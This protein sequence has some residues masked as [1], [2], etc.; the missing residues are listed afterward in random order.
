MNEKLQQ[1]YRT[2]WLGH[3]DRKEEDYIPKI[4]FTQQKKCRK[5]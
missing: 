4:Y 2:D 5:T 3:L 1:D